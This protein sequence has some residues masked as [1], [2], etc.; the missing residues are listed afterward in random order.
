M[1]QGPTKGVPIDTDPTLGLNSNQVVPSQAAVVTYVTNA[2]QNT[3]LPSTSTENQI[4]LSNNLAPP[5][6]STAT[7]PATAA[8][9]DIIYASA[10]NVLTTLA[11]GSNAHVLTLSAGVPVWAPNTTFTWNVETGT[12]ANMAVNN[13]YIANNAGTVTF[14]L[15]DSAAV[16]DIVRVTS[17]QAAWSIAQNA[18]E[19][20][21]F[22]SSSTTTG[23]GGSLTSTDTRD[24]IELVCVVA[25][26]DWQALSSIGNITI[27]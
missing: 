18:G 3:A 23:V 6:W 27:V 25:N 16:G 17:I 4:L 2:V 9:G 10:T 15:P 26:T 22:G 13:G 12:S 11:A 1:T 21:Y 5:E 20:I 7:Y 19:T 14:T 8:T 24:A